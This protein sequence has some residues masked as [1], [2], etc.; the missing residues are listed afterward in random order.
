[1]CYAGGDISVSRIPSKAACFSDCS[2]FLEY[3]EW[4]PFRCFKITQKSWNLPQA[5]ARV[6][7]FPI[8]PWVLSLFPAVHC[9]IYPSS[10]TFPLSVGLWCA[11]CSPL[12]RSSV[13]CFLK[14]QNHCHSCDYRSRRAPL[15]CESGWL[16]LKACCLCLITM[17]SASCHIRALGSQW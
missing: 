17:C 4:F 2:T 1:M 10:S 16:C 13:K 11:A 5:Q 6:S 8:P 3:T 7:A 15:L 12:I 9:S 14:F